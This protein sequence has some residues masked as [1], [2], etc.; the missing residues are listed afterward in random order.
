VE[1]IDL[2]NV[3]PRSSKPLLQGAP[4][5]RRFPGACFVTGGSKGIGKSIGL[6]ICQHFKMSLALVGRDAHSL[7]QA[8]SEAAAF[9]PASQILTFAFDV[10]DNA[11]MKRAM[12]ETAV[13]L[14]GV[15]VLVCSAGINRRRHAV[16]T[17]GQQFADP[18]PWQE[19]LDINLSSSMSATGYAM[20][21]LI[22]GRSS[23]GVAPTIFFVG[24]RIVRLG[25]APGQQ[26][27]AA[28]KMGLAGFSQSIHQEVRDHGCVL[29]S[30]P[31]PAAAAAAATAVARR[32]LTLQ[33]GRPGFAL[34]C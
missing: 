19:L 1:S 9:V 14:G 20:P 25:G 3:T 29:F 12:D 28:S 32:H 17:D 2:S 23:A 11:A 4:P 6:A 34:A 33:R 31:V 21:H 30:L 16:S 10:R 7:S 5:L 15:T 18:K 8:A 13:K 22:K 24:S 27:Y 26:S